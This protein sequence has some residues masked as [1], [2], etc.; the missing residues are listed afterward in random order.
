MIHPKVP[1]PP[2]DDVEPQP[3][4]ICGNLTYCREQSG[5]TTVPWC[6]KHTTGVRW[7]ETDYP[8]ATTVRMVNTKYVNPPPDSLIPD[9]AAEARA[10]AFRIGAIHEIDPLTE[11]LRRT[12]ALGM[13]HAAESCVCGPEAI[14]EEATL[15]ENGGKL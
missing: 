1:H 3:C 15:I 2:P 10:M 14:E 7:S 12:F 6:P 11:L 9:F 13:R 4:S 8:D 5:N